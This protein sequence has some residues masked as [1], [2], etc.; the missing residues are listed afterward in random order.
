M[1]PGGRMLLNDEAQPGAG[2]H[3]SRPAGFAGAV[4][5]AFGAVS[6]KLSGRHRVS[7]LPE[8]PL[9][10]RRSR[11]KIS[12]PLGEKQFTGLGTIRKIG[13]LA[14]WTFYCAAMFA[15][16]LLPSVFPM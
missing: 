11:P 10:K 15:G 7:L 16:G 6:G 12:N 3:F 4:E 14:C 8:K 1:Q 9:Q 5:V 2:R 13:G